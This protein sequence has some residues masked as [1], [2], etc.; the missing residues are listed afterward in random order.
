M[1]VLVLLALFASLVKASNLR[2]IIPLDQGGETLVGDSAAKDMVDS[3]L[4]SGGVQRRKVVLTS[5]IVC[6]LF[7]CQTQSLTRNLNAVCVSSFC[8][9][10]S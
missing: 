10:Q 1:R 9:S 2:I 6:S 5:A 7:V 4:D 8:H 3:G